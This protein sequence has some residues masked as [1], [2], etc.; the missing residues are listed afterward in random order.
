MDKK[1]TDKKP[2]GRLG[3]LLAE[4]VLRD[5]FEGKNRAKGQKMMK[6]FKKMNDGG[7]KFIVKAPM[8]HFLRAIWLS[9]PETPIKNIQKVLSFTEVVP[10]IADFK[11]EKE[12][13]DEILMIDKLMGGKKID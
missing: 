8:S 11:S 2:V 3:F 6:M 1:Q 7:A 13:M 5:M 12:C 10:K 9:N 4:D